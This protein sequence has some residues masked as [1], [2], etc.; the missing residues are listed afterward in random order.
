M[1]VTAERQ[2]TDLGSGLGPPRI[3][4]RLRAH[5]ANMSGLPVTGRCA[6]AW[7]CE[8]SHYTDDEGLIEHKRQIGEMSLDYDQTIVEVVVT[9][10]EVT[11]GADAG[12]PPH[13]AI[14]TYEDGTDCIFHAVHLLSFGGAEQLAGVLH[15]L[16]EGR[17]LNDALLTAQGLLD[18]I[19]RAQR[20]A[21]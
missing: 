21:G 9:S 11:E 13:A 16:G 19:K 18:I 14:W 10:T 4:P 5:I 2:V 17:W 20:R 8:G 7:W 6:T 1:T 12:T 3:P 15:T